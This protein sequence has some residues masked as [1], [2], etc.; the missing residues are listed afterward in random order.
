[1]TWGILRGLMPDYSG[2]YYDHAGVFLVGNIIS[3][4]R[5]ENPEEVVQTWMF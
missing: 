4:Q 1:M 5:M 2:A 3:H